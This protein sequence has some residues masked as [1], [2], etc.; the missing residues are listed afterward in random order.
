MFRELDW[1][2]GRQYI[3]TDR[4]KLKNGQTAWIFFALYGDE[5]TDIYNVMFA[6]GNKKKHIRNWM[7]RLD[8]NQY[9][10]VDKE[11]GNCGLEG[12]LWARKKILE[13]EEYM[14]GEYRIVVYG[15][16]KRRERLYRTALSKYGYK[17]NAVTKEM[18]K[19][20]EN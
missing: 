14:D 6:I 13:F 1:I 12:L 2:E 10:V 8:M 18:Y 19:N 4:K 5:Y 15:S 11:T 20:I 7:L 3:L 17:W 9:S 16:D